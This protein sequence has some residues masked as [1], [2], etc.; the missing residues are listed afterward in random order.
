MVASSGA[1]VSVIERHAVSYI[2]VHLTVRVGIASLAA[3]IKVAVGDLARKSVCGRTNDE[4]MQDEGDQR[5][6]KGFNLNRVR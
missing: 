3:F 5:E 1:S 2:H 4:R 6:K